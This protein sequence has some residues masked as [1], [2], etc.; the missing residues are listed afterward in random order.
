[1]QRLDLLL[2]DLS[3]LIRAAGEHLARALYQPLAPILDLVGMNIELLGEL[4]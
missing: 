1:M 3:A 2:A 4:R